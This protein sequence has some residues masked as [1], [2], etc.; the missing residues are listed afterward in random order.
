MAWNTQLTND[1][2]F[3]CTGDT[4]EDCIARL[5]QMQ[6]YQPD[7]QD[8]VVMIQRDWCPNW[9]A[10]LARNLRIDGIAYYELKK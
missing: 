8:V 1:D 10:R 2:D 9:L 4:K 3:V 5:R 7:L 6:R